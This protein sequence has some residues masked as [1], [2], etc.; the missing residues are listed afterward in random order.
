MKEIFKDVKGFKN[1]AIS[2]KG[3]VINKRTGFI[4]K[5]AARGVQLYITMQKN[6]GNVVRS[7][8]K[9]MI[10]HFKNANSEDFAIHL[11]YNTF[12]N[13]ANNLD[14]VDTRSKLLQFR[15]N[16]ERKNRCVYK[17]HWYAL[18]KSPNRWRGKLNIKFKSID[19]GYFKTRKLAEE[20][21]AKVFKREMG[22]E[23]TR[24]YT[25]GK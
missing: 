7:L 16:G 6:R 17:N 2:N 15:K 10:L 24:I 8:S 22:F 14:K 9:L 11:D 18:G 19:V 1:Y 3:Y 20:A 5:P 25:K 13:R 23:M 4:L 21:C 12:D